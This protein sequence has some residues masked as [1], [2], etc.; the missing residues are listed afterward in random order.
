MEAFPAL[1]ALCAGNSPVTG[2][3]PSQ[4]ASNADFWSFFDVGA[5][6]LLNKQTKSWI[7][8]DVRLHNVSV[9]SS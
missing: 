7:A 6:K 3:F 2:K 1:L 5:H 4:M 8:G 9:T